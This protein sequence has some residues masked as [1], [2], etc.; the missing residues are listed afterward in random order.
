MYGI[1]ETTKD[2]GN[3]T[4][5]S[6][7]RENLILSKCVVVK[8]E[9]SGNSYFEIEFAD[10]KGL[11]S[12]VSRRFYEPKEGTFIKS[13]EDLEKAIK[14]LNNVFGN[15]TRT[16][17]SPTFMLKDIK[18]FDDYITKLAEALNKVIAK[19]ALVRAVIVLNNSDFPTLRGYAPVIE[20]MS[21][22]ANESILRTS[23]FDKLVES[24]DA[25][26]PDADD[27]TPS[28]DRNAAAVW[29]APNEENVP[30]ENTEEG[31]K[32]PF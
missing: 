14:K 21:V 26:K 27:T 7:V 29:N 11:Y 6:G 19:K 23:R 4:M 18:S 8:D 15:F 30:S 24:N 22:K 10:V 13:K 5:P 12:P 17:I 31:D 16:L 3:L 20:S 2:K 9:E 25:P 28:A 1:D 32:L